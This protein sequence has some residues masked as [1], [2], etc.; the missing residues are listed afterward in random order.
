MAGDSV[1]GAAGSSAG[2]GG[3]SNEGGKLKFSL[4]KGN[5]NMGDKIGGGKLLMSA[6]KGKENGKLRFLQESGNGPK[7]GFSG[8]DNCGS[9][10]SEQ[11]AMAMAEQI[12]AKTATALTVVIL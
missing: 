12:T 11:S 8:N 10:I 7:N 6:G 2:T 9:L 5:G 3:V 4:E 1:C